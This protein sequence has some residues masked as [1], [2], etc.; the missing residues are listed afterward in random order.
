[1]SIN[2]RRLFLCLVIGIKSV[3]A[4]PK[5]I[6]IWFLS[7]D[8]TTY[9]DS[10]PRYE[11][12]LAQRNLQCQ[13]MGDY[14]FDPQVGLYKKGEG[15]EG[16]EEVDLTR[17]EENKKYEFIAPHKGVDRELIVCDK[18]STM[19]DIFCGK[20]SKSKVGKKSKLEVWV[21]VSS[22][23]KQ[24]DFPGLN[25]QCQRERFLRLLSES[26]TKEQGNL[27]IYFFEEYRKAAGMLD[28]VCLN[29][30]LND[31]KR[32]V[33]DLKRSEADHV[34]II[35]DVFEAQD[36]FIDAV[37]ALGVTKIKGLDRPF[38]ASMIKKEVKR[39]QKLCI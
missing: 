13:Q 12:K 15:L 27:G 29:S 35:T 10:R 37:E 24:V 20:S 25:Q 17:V 28:R 7:T 8:S 16:L 3:W 23:M 18:D 31:M 33:D 9:L 2:L 1:M 6:E 39:F 4:I 14:C 30:G 26:C 22:T 19:F 11:Q 32:I 38:Y 34:L 21:D 36:S 5:S